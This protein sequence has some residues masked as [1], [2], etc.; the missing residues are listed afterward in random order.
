MADVRLDFEDLDA[1]ALPDLCMKCAAPATT[2]VGKTFSYTPPWAQMIGIFALAFMKRRSVNI[3]LCEKHKGDWTWRHLVTWLGLAVVALP[4]FAGLAVLSTTGV[5]RANEPLGAALVLGSFGLLIAWL[6]TVIVVWA[7]AIR[8]TEITDY[9][10]TL[11]NLSY[12]WVRAYHEQ[13]RGYGPPPVEEL[14]REHFGR[15]RLPRGRG[16]RGGPPDDAF[17]RG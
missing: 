9:T 8:T 15:G 17:E 10:I 6:V 2:R 11:K 14:A 7:T 4:F 3:P 12:D 1:D 13:G 5:S 16:P